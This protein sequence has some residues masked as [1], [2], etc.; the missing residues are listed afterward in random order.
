[1]NLFQ[2]I[3]AGGITFSNYAICSVAAI[4]C[5]IIVAFAAAY[6][7]NLSKSMIISLIL[8]PVIVETVI[9]MVNGNI[10]TGIA[11][12]G[13]FSLVRFR[14]VA[15]KAKDIAAVFLAMA[16]GL[17]CAAGYV[18]IA[19][20]FALV[21]SVILVLLNLMPMQ[22]EKELNL[23]ITVPEGLNYTEIFEEEFK[24]YTKNARLISI[25]T[26][27]LG[28][29]YRLQYKI[30]LKDRKNVKE[31]IDELRC[32]NGNLEISICEQHYDGEEL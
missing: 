14:S 2:S 20:G 8:L 22:S 32:K 10:G 25:K 30:E 5:G 9:I 16:C 28:S 13:A 7:S 19:L 24:K 4:I 21:V 11:V 26:A 15:G 6:K 17:S 18:Y 1:M 27:N 3:T 29:L 31:F 23:R 12:A